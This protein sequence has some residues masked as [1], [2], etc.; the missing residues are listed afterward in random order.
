MSEQLAETWGV[1]SQSPKIIKLYAFG[2]ETN[3]IIGSA[4]GYP[5]SGFFPSDEEAIKNARVMAASFEL[6]EAL[7]EAASWLVL[8]EA[9]KISLDG[10][11]AIENAKAAIAKAKGA[12]HE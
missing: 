12:S 8:L 1:S 3:V 9:N 6:L 2:K 10:V 7:Q 11:K 5:D 4:S